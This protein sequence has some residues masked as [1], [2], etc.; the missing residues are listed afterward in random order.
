MFSSL[1]AADRYP[2]GSPS[3]GQG[4]R[5][6]SVSPAVA[7]VDYRPSRAGL[8]DSSASPGSTAGSLQ[9]PPPLGAR[10]LIILTGSRPSS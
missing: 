5:L 9:P 6:G 1:A 4:P 10:Q 7:P 8:A 2:I 3:P